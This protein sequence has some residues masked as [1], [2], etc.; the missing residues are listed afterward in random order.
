M[1]FRSDSGLEM[2]ARLIKNIE[3]MR[4]RNVKTTTGTLIYHIA[5]VTTHT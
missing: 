1:G 2:N 3:L 4:G 5:Y